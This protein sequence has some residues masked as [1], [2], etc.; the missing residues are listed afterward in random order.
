VERER[1]LKQQTAPVPPGPAAPAEDVIPAI[2][3]AFFDGALPKLRDEATSFQDLC[4]VG[5]NL[6]TIRRDFLAHLTPELSALYEQVR[7]QF[8]LVLARR[9]GSA[10]EQDSTDRSVGLVKRY[11]E[12]VQPF[13]GSVVYESWS[14]IRWVG[15]TEQFF[16]AVDVGY[17]AKTQSGEPQNYE[18]IFLI[19]HE[20]IVDVV[21]KQTGLPGETTVLVN[22]RQRQAKAEADVLVREVA[23]R[24]VYGSEG[25][26]FRFSEP[27]RFVID[28]LRAIDEPMKKKLA[29]QEL[30]RFGSFLATHQS[31]EAASAM[32]LDIVEEFAREAN[33]E[34]A[35][36]QGEATSPHEGI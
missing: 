17:T 6:G 3:R 28:R 36:T 12:A 23:E 11:L 14:E 1:L 26:K 13:A 27:P 9:I 15:I 33:R 24:L 34:R 29:L 18:H 30:V 22:P 16:W 8:A 32:L 25:E 7:E 2:L 35:I 5:L 31:S 20:R 4:D 19:Q 21:E 10:P